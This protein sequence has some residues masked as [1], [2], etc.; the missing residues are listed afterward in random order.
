VIEAVEAVVR[1]LADELPSVE[2]VWIRHTTMGVATQTFEDAREFS[3]ILE[4]GD[5]ISLL[6][7]RYD[8]NREGFAPSHELLYDEGVLQCTAG[9]A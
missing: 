9:T 4:V 5:V 8:V 1:R 7:R 2:G 3:L 6:V